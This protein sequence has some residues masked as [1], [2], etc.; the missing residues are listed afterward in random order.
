MR[1][2]EKLIQ[3]NNE[4]HKERG[5]FLQVGT[6]YALFVVGWTLVPLYPG[7]VV[8]SDLGI[9]FG[10][11]LTAILMNVCLYF[12]MVFLFDRLVRL[13]L[14]NFQLE[15]GFRLLKSAMGGKGAQ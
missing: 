12:G 11:S 2:L 4:E 10:I 14:Y 13:R 3:Y 15:F 1:V 8:T 7:L 5:R 9:R 6:L